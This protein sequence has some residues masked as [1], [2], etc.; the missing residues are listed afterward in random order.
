MLGV[1]CM[2]DFNNGVEVINKFA[3]SEKKITVNYN[4]YVYMLK[5]PDP[6]REKIMI[7][8]I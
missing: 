5:F 1:V 3:G 6:I 4:G 2:I 8:V 7:L